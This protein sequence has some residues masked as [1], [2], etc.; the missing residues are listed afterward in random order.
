ML[1]R[2][3]SSVSMLRIL[4]TAGLT[5]LAGLRSAGPWEIAARLS[6]ETGFKSLC[7]LE[8]LV[9]EVS[10]GLPGLFREASPLSINAVVEVQEEG[11][12]ALLSHKDSS[13][14][15]CMLELF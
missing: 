2:M 13:R 1:G 10:G 3:L 9:E 15:S 6:Q 11:N 8:K 14:V 12:W 5:K 7:L 4:V